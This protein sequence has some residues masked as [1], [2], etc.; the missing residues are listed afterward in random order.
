MSVYWLS[1]LGFSQSV[2]WSDRQSVYLS[3]CQSVSWP[4]RQS[5]RQCGGQAVFYRAVYCTSLSFPP[6]HLCHRVFIQ[7]VSVLAL[8]QPINLSVFFKVS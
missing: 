6:M 1:V 3:A 2:G 5:V 7:R 8:S 4:V